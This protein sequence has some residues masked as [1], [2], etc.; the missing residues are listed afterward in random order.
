MTETT[1]TPPLWQ[2]LSGK[3]LTTEAQMME[4]RYSRFMILLTDIAPE[5]D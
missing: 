1:A 4:Y 3:I 2:L 5:T